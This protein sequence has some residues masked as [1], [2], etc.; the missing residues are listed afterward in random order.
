MKLILLPQFRSHF[1]TMTVFSSLTSEKRIYIGG[2]LI[3]PSWC[4]LVLQSDALF[5]ETTLLSTVTFLTL[6]PSK[7]H[8]RLAT[9][10]ETRSLRSLNPFSLLLP[11]VN[12]RTNEARKK[13]MKQIA[14][15]K[16][17]YFTS[18]N[19]PRA[20]NSSSR[21]IYEPFRFNGRI[22]RGKMKLIH[23]NV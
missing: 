11:L 10:S 8:Q 20:V 5:R 14:V 7:R 21:C 2:L 1:I 17:F 22:N 6:S 9:K 19:F 15:G 4:R 18:G 16:S 13:E 12:S 23:F 3:F